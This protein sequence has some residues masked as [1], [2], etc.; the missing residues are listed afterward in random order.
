MIENEKRKTKN[1]TR[2]LSVR[3]PEVIHDKVIKHLLLLPVKKSLNQ[4]VLESM[5]KNMGKQSKL[6]K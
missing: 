2:H 4:F 3:I 5:V 1:D 6:E